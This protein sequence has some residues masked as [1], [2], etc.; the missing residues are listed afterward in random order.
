MK[1]LTFFFGFVFILASCDYDVAEELYPVN[2]CDTRDLSYSLDIVPIIDANCY[3][4]HAAQL[5]LGNVTL[6]G[7]NNI[8]VYVDNGKLLGTIKHEDGFQTMP[9]DAGKIDQCLIDKV[10]QWIDDGAENN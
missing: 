1:K 5:N 6:E 4:C 9:Q 10:E 8:K 7:Y 3:R 2:G